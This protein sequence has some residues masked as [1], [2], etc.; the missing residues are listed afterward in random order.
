MMTSSHRPPLASA[1]SARMDSADAEP[2]DQ[3]RINLRCLSISVVAALVGL[4]PIAIGAVVTRPLRSYTDTEASPRPSSQASSTSHAHKRLPP[5][6]SPPCIAD[7]LNAAFNESATSM[8]SGLYIHGFDG[9]ANSINPV[10]STGFLSFNYL[11]AGLL[12]INSRPIYDYACKIQGVCAGYVIRINENSTF[13]PLCFFTRDGCTNN[14][15]HCGCGNITPVVSTRCRIHDYS[16]P[17]I[18]AS[19]F[20]ARYDLSTNTLENSAHIPGVDYTS[21]VSISKRVRHVP[22][23]NEVVFPAYARDP[24]PVVAYFLTSLRA[25]RFIPESGVPMVFLNVSREKPFECV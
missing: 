5:P 21:F 10:S 22:R 1:D 13:Q 6:S 25:R 19:D 24:L 16:A 11:I 18:D 23:W 3:T 14:R 12:S 20:V 7:Q 17:H 2:T 15:D 8:Y 4:Y 9:Q